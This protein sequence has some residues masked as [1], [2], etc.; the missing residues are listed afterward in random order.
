MAELAAVL[1]RRPT[2]QNLID[3]GVAAALAASVIMSIRIAWEPRAAPR[4]HAFAFTLG[5]TIGVLSLFGRRAPRLVL[6]ASA[7]ALQIYY[8]SG[9]PG[10]WPALPL[11]RPA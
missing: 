10:I 9:Y 7:A 6:F 3:L 11:S 2:R 4:P 1:R 8:L 5:I